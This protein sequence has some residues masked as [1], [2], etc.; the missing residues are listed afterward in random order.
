[1]FECI[2]G[3]YSNK[4]NYNHNSKSPSNE[5]LPMILSIPFACCSLINLDFLLSQAA[6]FDE[7]IILPF[8]IFTNLG[9]LFYVFFLY[10]KNYNNIIL[11]IV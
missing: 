9:F 3:E 5:V 8:L 10:F 2:H 4:Q 6:Q 11:Y 1:M 7:S